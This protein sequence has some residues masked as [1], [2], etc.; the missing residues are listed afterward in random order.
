M[1]ATPTVKAAMLP[2]VE[3]TETLYKGW[4]TLLKA[5][6]K[7]GP[8]R[9]DREIEHHGEG[10]AV[11]PY[12]PGRRVALTIRL[13]RAPLLVRGET[14]LLIEAPAG[15]IEEGE[16]PGECVRREALEE[17][18]VRLGSLEPLG[19]IW[20]M[21]GISTERMHMFLAPYGPADRIA[22]GGGV[23]GENENITVTEMPLADLA[24]LA[25]ANALPDIR[26]LVM[27]QS[28]RLRH[29]DLFGPAT[30]G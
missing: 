20:T 1:P 4:L 25:D 22:A 3:S 24:R 5:K 19:A 12:D 15:L 10:A 17:A 16:D 6:L 13:P 27:V 8:D 21:P 2:I 28:L 29:P 26:T 9:F 7:L 30:G 18:G 14:E 23:P 11:L